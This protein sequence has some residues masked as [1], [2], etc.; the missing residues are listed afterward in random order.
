MI[1]RGA[2]VTNN[3]IAESFSDNFSGNFYGYIEGYYGQLLSWSA[4]HELLAVMAELGMNSYFY[5]PKDDAAHRF[6]WRQSYDADWRRGFA[7]FAAA[8]ARNG[9]QII[10]G[11]APGLDFKFASLD[12]PRAGDFACLVD[13]AIQL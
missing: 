7:D 4:R 1:T 10:A 5:A 9:I 3:N 12:Q 13:K 2:L 6:D 11:I 8:A